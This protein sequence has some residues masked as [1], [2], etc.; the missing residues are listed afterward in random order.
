MPQWQQVVLIIVGFGALIIALYCL[1]F[2]VPVKRF[3]ERI[4]S[5]GGGIEGVESHVAGVHDEIAGRLAGLEETIGEQI[6]Q[7]REAAQNRLERL[8]KDSRES[9]REL[10]RLRKDVQALQAGLRQAGSDDMK[11]NRSLESL[12]KQLQQLRGDFDALDVELRES[13]RQLVSDSFNTVESTVLSALDAVQEEIL[14][15][16]SEPS[17]RPPKGLEPRQKPDR[18]PPAGFGGAERSPGDKIIPM[19]PLFAGLHRNEK[20]AEPEKEEESTAEE[21]V[22]DEKAETPK[23]GGKKGRKAKKRKKS[24]KKT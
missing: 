23:A 19:E 11:V 18:R 17:S 24:K 13:V 10:E 2:M 15:G 6:T 20:A 4:N 7:S 9:Q 8:A 12:A 21:S 14:Y 22:P 3:W 16:A 1:F 5:L